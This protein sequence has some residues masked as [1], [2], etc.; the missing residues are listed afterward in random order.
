MATNDEPLGSSSPGVLYIN[1]G[2]FDQAINSID[3]TWSDRFGIDRPTLYGALKNFTDNGGALAFADESALQAYTPESTNVLAIDLGAGNYF[4]WDGATWELTPF[5]PVTMTALREILT[6]RSEPRNMSAKFA[7]SLTDSRGR[8]MFGVHRDGYVQGEFRDLP[9]RR[10]LGHFRWSWSDSAGNVIYGLRWDGTIYSQNDSSN[11]IDL[12]IWGPEGR[13]GLFASV[14]GVWH[15]VTQGPEVLSAALT[16]KTINYRQRSGGSFISGQVSLPEYGVL[17]DYVTDWLHLLSYGQSLSMGAYST[18]V[19]TVTPPLANRIYSPAFGIRLSDQDGVVSAGD[20]TPLQPM[21]SNSTEVPHA[22]LGAQLSRECAIPDSAALL[23]SCHGRGGMSISQLGPSSQFYANLLTTVTAAHS[24]VTAAGKTYRVPFVDYIQGE[25][26]AG[27]ATGVYLA[28]LIS[29]RGALEADIHAI[30]GDAAKIPFLLDQISNW[31]S[32][33]RTE[34]NIP[35]EQLQAAL[36]H[37]ADF[38]CAGPKYWLETAD[39][40]EHLTALS[41]MRAG[42]MHA[43]AA[44]AILRGESWLPTHVYSAS[45]DGAIIDLLVNTP[46]GPLVIDTKNVSDPGNY[47]LRYVDS[48]GSATISGVV[49]T[50]NRI[51][52]TLS[53]VPTGTGGY[54]GI[55]DTGTS[56][57]KGG[58]TTGPRACLRDSD[59]IYDM[60]G[61]PVWNW[62]CHQ[63]ISVN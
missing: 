31:T 54:I 40:G 51:R 35:L 25:A 10:I 29:L 26:D 12:S 13:R 1:S 8:L 14:N 6:I 63:R 46:R 58:P 33:D 21:T 32:H 41:S 11:Q 18:P 7:H 53:A 47:G 49:V 22:Q 62:I 9:G 24:S 43:G 38:V 28:A 4:V 3:M 56:G 52:V 60:N 27:A 15:Q 19:Q 57:A 5:N 55:A 20:V 16:G 17:A 44:A 37:P 45:R 50:G 42:V 23:L 36:E 48:T 61:Q 34:T 39:D 30:T 59:P 2:N